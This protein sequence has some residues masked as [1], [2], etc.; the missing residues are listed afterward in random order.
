M[1]AS[2]IALTTDFN[3]AQMNNLLKAIVVNLSKRAQLKMGFA[4]AE[5]EMDLF[6][7]RT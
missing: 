3:T 4:Q 7:L 5:M 2:V 6:R 1:T